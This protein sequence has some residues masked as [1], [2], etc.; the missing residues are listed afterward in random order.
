MFACVS[1]IS[2]ERLLVFLAMFW[3]KACLES[4]PA[5]HTDLTV[6]DTAGLITPGYL[7]CSFQKK[8]KVRLTAYAV[9][10]LSLSCRIRQCWCEAGGRCVGVGELDP[11][12]SSR[13][14][15]LTL[16][17]STTFHNLATDLSAQI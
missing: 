14:A 5:R 2:G 9:T 11:S 17:Q 15:L 10:T 12:V 1:G 13:L 3:P 7:V 16:L 8:H 4:K 6:T